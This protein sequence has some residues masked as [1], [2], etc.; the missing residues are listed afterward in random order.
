[1]RHNVS[2]LLTVSIAV[3]AAVAA[4]AAQ[5]QALARGD[6]EQLKRKVASI[7]N[8]SRT[9]SRGAARTTVTERELNAFLAFEAADD[10]PT[11]VVDPRISIHGADRV[12]ARAVVDL[13]RVRQQW[14]PTS[15]LDPVQYLRG[16]LPVTATGRVRARNGLATLELEAADIAGVPVPKFILQ[17]IVSYYSRSA[18]HPGGIDLDEPMVL[19]ARIRDI[20]VEPGQA[21]VVQ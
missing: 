13:D 15:V 17:Q 9:A 11:G 12:T 19:P 16:R 1:M 3:A 14:N 5:G 18:S 21:I 10:F 8:R 4:V 2:K 20:E 7:A 6:A